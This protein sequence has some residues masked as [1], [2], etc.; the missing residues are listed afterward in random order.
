LISSIAS[1]GSHE[2][3]LQTV[4]D[5]LNSEIPETIAQNSGEVDLDMTKA[6]TDLKMLEY[7]QKAAMQVAG[8]ILQPTLLDFLR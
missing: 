4:K 3:R 1:L 5:R 6:I 7:T 8:R 2:E